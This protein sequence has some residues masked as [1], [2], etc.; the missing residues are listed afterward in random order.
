MTAYEDWLDNNPAVAKVTTLSAPLSRQLRMKFRAFPQALR[1]FS[2]VNQIHHMSLGA[3]LEDLVEKFTFVR[4]APHGAVQNHPRIK[5][6][7]SIID[8]VFRVIAVEYLGRTDL[9][10]VDPE[11]AAP[12]EAPT[13]SPTP[14]SPKSLTRDS[15]DAPFCDKCGHKT[16][17]NGAC[18]KCLNCGE[19]L[20]CS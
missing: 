3:P 17:R 11:E 20:G 13:P 6:A 14:V 15:S 10:H 16:V 4:F 12:T 7:T 2:L 5:F 1:F 19:S 9:G 18:Y 8:L